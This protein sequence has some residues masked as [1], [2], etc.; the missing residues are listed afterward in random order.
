M[1][2][3]VSGILRLF[4]IVFVFISAHDLAQADGN[5]TSI[6]FVNSKNSIADLSDPE[7][8]KHALSRSEKTKI[9]VENNINTAFETQ[10]T[11]PA[12]LTYPII[13]SLDKNLLK[14]L[15]PDRYSTFNM[16]SRDHSPLHRYNTSIEMNKSP[17]GGNDDTL[18]NFIF[19]YIFDTLTNNMLTF[20]FNFTA[21]KDN[22][23]NVNMFIVFRPLNN[24]LIKYSRTQDTESRQSI[25]EMKFIHNKTKNF[26]FVT[27]EDGKST[28]TGFEFEMRF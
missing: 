15:T 12:Y 14:R 10:K 24:F 16:P 13:A 7:S 28:A 17:F 6:R 9:I 18:S 23:N 25:F 21:L 5:D 27:I 19:D 11:E 22:P 1:R 20:N 26:T 2:P 4:F 3:I 8:I